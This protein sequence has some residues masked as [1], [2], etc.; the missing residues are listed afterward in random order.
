VSDRPDA[1]AREA[2]ISGRRTRFEGALRNM[3]KI[4]EAQ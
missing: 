2:D 3:K 1:A 4:A